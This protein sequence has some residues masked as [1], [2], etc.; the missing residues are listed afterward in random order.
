MD[1]KKGLV[2]TWKCIDLTTNTLCQD[3]TG[4]LILLGSSSSV[5]IAG[6]TFKV[7]AS[8][9]F[10][11]IVSKFKGGVFSTS[12]PAYQNVKTQAAKALVP[13]MTMSK[14]N[15]KINPNQDLLIQAVTLYPLNP[16]DTYT[17]LWQVIGDY[18][19]PSAFIAVEK[20]IPA[21]NSQYL[22]IKAFTLNSTG[23]YTLS[24]QIKA[25]LAQTTEI[26]TFSLVMNQPPSGGII[27]AYPSN[28]TES[29]TL[30]NLTAIGWVDPDNDNPVNYTM[31]YQ[32]GP[33]AGIVKI[34]STSLSVSLI[35]TL[36]AGDRTNGTNQLTIILQAS[37]ALG[38]STN[39]T[40]TVIVS[41]CS[42]DQRQQ[43]LLAM[44][45]A[46]D[47][48]DPISLMNTMGSALNY[49]NDTSGELSA[50]TKKTLT[51]NLISSN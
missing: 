48:T 2:F 9:Q 18:I 4:N 6:N 14:R 3:T 12:S 16:N 43:N 31:Y 1:Q 15:I 30:F 46:T 10:S 5:Y 40:T 35:T 23:N 29:V 41:P 36:P 51:T 44:V 11:L 22:K 38:A 34:S 20:G 28:G 27:F 13:Q 45:N 47:K 26:T 19:D 33:Q 25:T 37:D 32:A 49:L 21:L 8:M 50:D 7:N 17:Y 24:C 39:A 42:M